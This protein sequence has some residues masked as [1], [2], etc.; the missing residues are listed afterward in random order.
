MLLFMYCS[1]CCC[2]LCYW[3]LCC[4]KPL[5]Q[6]LLLLWMRLQVGNLLYLFQQCVLRV[7]MSQDLFVMFLAQLAKY[8]LER[9]SV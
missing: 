7:L 5:L 2:F 6:H 1:L 8:R 9:F 3:F 4:W